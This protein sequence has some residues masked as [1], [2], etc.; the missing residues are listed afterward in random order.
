MILP[1]PPRGSL[2]TPLGRLGARLC[3]LNLS[4]GRLGAVLGASWAVW[5]RQWAFGA[6]VAAVRIE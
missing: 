2:G 1:W 4:S 5:D 3:C 6:V